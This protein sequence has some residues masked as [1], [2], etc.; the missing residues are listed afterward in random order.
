L[1]TRPRGSHVIHR[2]PCLSALPSDTVARVATLC[3][4]KGPPGRHRVRF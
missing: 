4:I 1:F 2:R 3:I